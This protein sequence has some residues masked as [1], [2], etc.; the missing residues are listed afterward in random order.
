MLKTSKL[1]RILTFTV[2]IGLLI[3]CNEST[4][5]NNSDSL[6]QTQIDS[7][8][9]EKPKLI[10]QKQVLDYLKIIGDSVEIPSFDIE[11]KLSQKAEKKLKNDNESVIV[12]AYFSGDPIENIPNKYV[13]NVE[14]GEL[15]LLSYP[16]ELTDK[17]LAK[18]EN[19]KFSLE[20]YNLLANKDIRLLINVYS[21]RK[22]TNI[23]LLDCGIL[24][25]SMSKIKGKRFTIKG[26]LIYND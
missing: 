10:E 11:L 5:K 19:I 25:D 7:I 17:R 18:F 2:L 1:M 23:N 21:G 15:F 14:M 8:S 9:K 3:S 16:I 12:M 6:A 20:L 26:K 4:Q 22:S 24:Q 13:D